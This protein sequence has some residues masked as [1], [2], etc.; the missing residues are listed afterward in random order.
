MKI[1]LFFYANLSNFSS[2]HITDSNL[3]SLQSNGDKPFAIY[4]I[5]RSQHP[6]KRWGTTYFRRVSTREVRG[7]GCLNNVDYG[8]DCTMKLL[9]KNKLKKTATL[10]SG[11]KKKGTTSKFRAASK[12]KLTPQQS[13]RIDR[14]GAI[15]TLLALEE[16]IMFDGAVLATGAEVVQEQ[17]T[18][19]QANE[20]QGSQALDDN[21]TVKTSSNPLTDH[22]DL[23]SALSTVTAPS[24]RNEIVF[25]D[26]NVDD[27]QTLME[28]IDANAEVIM[29]DSTRDGIEQMA[30]ILGD[31]SDIDAI[32]I[33]SHG[34]QGEL[35]VGTGTLSMESMQ[36][37]YADELS[38]INQVLTNEADWLIYGCNFG[39][40]EIGHEAVNL[41][42]EL[43]G[44]DI[45]ASNDLTGSADLGADW[46]LEVETGTIETVVAVNAEIQQV[47]VEVLADGD[48]AV[49]FQEGVDGYAST[50][51]T[52]LDEFTPDTSYPSQTTVEVDLSNGGGG[53]EHALIRFDNLFGSG[54]GQIP[55]GST[56]ISATLT[57]D[58][59]DESSA[60]ATI[61][62][63]RMLATWSES[64][65]W[66]SMTSGISINDVEASSTADATIPNPGSTGSKVIVGLENTLQ[67]W[68]DGATNHG[69]AIISDN[70]NGLEFSSSENGTTSLR[71]QLTV[72]YRTTGGDIMTGLVGLWNV[73]ANA[74]DSSGNTNHG[75][76][77]GGALID[78]TDL[79]DKVGAGKLSLDGTD[80]YVDLASH[81]GNFS[82]LNEGTISAWIKTTSNGAVETIFSIT[83]SGDNQ[84]YAQL[85]IKNGALAWDV[86]QDNV[87]QVDVTT[88]AV[89][90]DGSWHH[91][92]ISVS[93]SGNI[94]YIDGQKITDLNYNAGSS[95]SA[96]FFN[97][98]SNLDAMAIGR[99]IDTSIGVWFFDGLV[100][101]VRVYSRSLSVADIAELAAEAPVA[102]NDAATTAVDTAVTVNLTSN[103]ID[104]DSETIA[105]LDVGNPTNGTVVNN[106]DGT[107]TYT[108]T[109]SYTGG[110]TFT[111]L[112]ADLDDTVSY[113]RLDGNGTDA[114]GSN[115]GTLTG[116]T[117]VPG[118]F[119]NALS[120]DE[121]DDKVIVPDFAINNEFSLSFKMKIDDNSGSNFQYLYG[122]GAINGF[123]NLN[124]FLVEESHASGGMLRTWIRDSNDATGSNTDL[125]FD[126]SH[127]IGDGQ[128]HTYTVTVANGEGTKVYLDGVLK[129][130]DATRGGDAI[131]PGTDIHFGA[132]EDFATVADRLYGGSLES[133]QLFNRALSAEE[134]ND[135]H[136]GGSSLATVTIGVGDLVVDTASDVADGDTS[137]IGALMS[138]KG[139][140][141]FISLR[142]AITAANNTTNGAS[143]DEI[144]FSIGTGLQTITLGAGSGLPDITDPL[145]LDA[146]TQSGYAGT[147]IIQIDGT[148]ATGATAGLRL[149]TNDS[150]IK[151]F[152]IHS[153]A[154]EGLEIDGS[155]GFGDNNTLQNNWLG[156]D[157]TGA[158][159]PNTEHGILITD[160]AA[161][162]QIGGTGLNE[163]NVVS[164]NTLSGIYIRKAGSDN[165]IVEGN[166]IGVA[167]NGSTVVANST[168]GV[169][170]DD[171]ATGNVIG[172]TATNAGNVIANNTL[173]GIAVTGATTDNA[174]LGNSIHSNTGLGVDL[175]DDGLTF[176]DADDAD[177]GSNDL[178]NFPVLTNVVQSGS[179][180]DIDF[181]ADLPAGNYRIEFFDNASG[182]DS[183]DFGE[184]QTFVGFAHITAT[185]AAGYES[186][187]TTLSTVT[188]SN[189]LNITATA[190]EADGTYTTFSST[191]EFGPQFLGAGVLEVTTTSDVSDGDTSSIAAPMGN[192]GA[193]GE[194]SL[195][196]AI[197][198][199][200]NTTNIGGNPDEIHF[201]IT[202][203]LVSGAHTI[204]V[205]VSGLDNITDAVIIDGTTDSDFS[206]T[207][208]IVLD[209]SSTG[210]GVEGL[211]L[212][213]GSDGSTI[214]GLVV[215]QFMDDGIQ[216]T[217]D[218]NTIVGNYLGTDVAGTAA[219]GNGEE[220]VDISGA[221]N[222]IGGTTAAD[223]NII[224][225]NTADG[226]EI[227]G[228]G[229]TGNMVLGNYIGTDVTGMLDLGNGDDGIQIS[230]AATSNTIGGTTATARNIISGNNSRGI[231][232]YGSGTSSNVIQGNYIG[233]DV[234]GTGDL[235]NTDEGILIDTQATNN[236]VGGTAAG[237]G[238]VISENDSYGIQLDGVGTTG[239]LVQG[240]TIGL[241]QA[242][243]AILGNA[244]HGVWITN[245]ATSNTIGGTVAGAKNY[246]SGN[247]GSGVFMDAGAGINTVSGNTIG[248]GSDGLTD[249]GNTSHG[250]FTN[251]GNN[252]IGGTTVNERNVISGNAG[253]GVYLATGGDTN[254]ILGNYIGLDEG[255][256]IA[257]GNSMNGILI[258][259]ASNII[260]GTTAGARNVISGNTSTGITINSA[261]SNTVQG[262][263]IGTNAA[264][265]VILG[266]T[267]IGIDVG[268]SN[269]TI[270]G[271]TTGTTPGGAATGAA[272]VIAGHTTSDIE[273]DTSDSTIIQGNY[274]G[275]NAAGTTALNGGSTDYGI[276]V[277]TGS[278]TTTVG[279]ST[280]SA[281]NIIAGHTEAGIA[282]VST[283]T[284]INGGTVR[285]NYVGVDTTG[286]A[287]LGSDGM[288]IWIDSDVIN[289]TVGGTGADDGN[290]IAAASSGVATGYAGGVVVSS[291]LAATTPTDITIQGNLV[292][293]NASGVA[294]AP[295]ANERAGVLAIGSVQD[296]TIGGTAAGAGNTI[297]SSTTGVEISETIFSATTVTPSN[298]SVLG[299]S[300]LDNVGLGVDI[301]QDTIDDVDFNADSNQ[302]VTFNDTDDADT[303]VNDL[304]NFPVI[305]NV[306]QNGADVDINF[307]VDLPAGNYRIEFFDNANGLDSSGF[308][309]GETFVGFAH[310]TVTGA[311]GYEAFSTTLSTV[312]ASN[313]LNITT[314]VTEADGTFT[315]FSSTSEF[316]PQFL[317]AGV[318][319]VTTTSDTNDGDISSIAALMG[320]RGADGEISLR[321]AIIATNN[322][323]NIG[324]NSDEIHF[325]ISAALVSGAH[326]IQVG[327][328]TDGSN[329]AL[330]DITDAVIIDG[331]TD[332]D[333]ST[334][335]I[336]ELDGS[337]AGTSAEGITFGSGSSGSTMRGLVINQFDLAGLRIDNSDNNTVVGNYIGTNVTGMSALANTD[338]GI[339]IVN[340]SQSNT[341]GGTTTADQNIISGN[342]DDG[343]RIRGGADGNIIIGNYIGVDATGTG[344][345]GNSGDGIELD[346][347]GSDDNTIGGTAANEGNII[348]FNSGDG[349]T[350]SNIGARGN[351]VL[352]NSIHS[353]TGIGID[354]NDDGV[355]AN[356]ANDADTGTG[357]NNLQN[358]PVLV[359]A[360]TNGAGNIVIAGSLDTDGLTQ[361]Y[362]IEF[363]SNTVATGEDAT[364]HG[365]GEN[366][367]G[368]V[369]VTTD[370]SGDVVFGANLSATV[371]A[372]DFITATAT[373]DNGG[374]SYGDTSEFATNFTA[375]LGSLLVVDTTSDMLDGTVTS[376]SALIADKGADGVISLREAITATNNT[377]NIGGNP[378][379]IHFNISAALVSG[380]HTITPGSALP[381]ITDAVIIDGTTEPDFGS[382]PVIELD[383]TSAGGVDGL[384][385]TS[386]SNGSTIRGLAINRFL[387]GIG[388]DSANNI[389][390][391]NFIGTDVTG[392]TD[393]G[394]TRD[395][396][397]LMIGGTNNTIGGTT[398]AQ[399][400]LISGQDRDG[401]RIDD[402]ANNI[403][404]GNY[405]GTDITGTVDLG[406]TSDGIQLDGTSTGTTIG[407]TTS[408]HRNV[409]SGNNGDGI[410]LSIGADS[411]TIS[412]NIIGLDVNGTSDLGNGSNGIRV[413]SDSNTIGGL[414]AGERNIISGN[415][416]DGIDINAS[417]TNLIWGNYIGT[418]I[419]GTLDLGNAGE[420]ILIGGAATGNSIGGNTSGHRN[421]ISG[422]NA[423]GIDF[424]DTGTMSNTVE[425]NYIGVDATGT[426]V[427][428]NTSA[429]VDFR[430]GAQSN[431][432]GGASAGQRN[433]ISANNVGIQ[434]RDAGTDNNTILG[435]YVG[436]DVTGAVALGN[437]TRGIYVRGGSSGTTIGG[438]ATDAGNIIAASGDQGIE[439]DNSS[440]NT[441]QGNY[442]GTNA[443]DSA[444]LGNTNEGLFIDNSAANNTIGGTA[445]GAGNTIAYNSQEGLNLDSDAG[446]GNSILRN[447]IHSNSALG[448]D[449]DNDGV[450]TNDLGD[451]DGG[452]NAQ[453]NY[454]ILTAAVSDEVGT[455]TISGSLNSSASTDYRIE[456]FASPAADSS[457]YG[458]AETYI[459]FASVTT[460]GSGNATISEAI[461]ATV[462]AGQ[463]VT[464]TATVDFGGSYGDTSEFAQNI[465]VNNTLIVDTTSDVSDGDTS[466]IAALLADKG[467]DGFVSLREAITATNNTTNINGSTPDEI[468]FNISAALVSGA[469]TI[470]IGASQ[471]DGITDAVII[472]GNTDSDFS[473]TPIIVL[474]GSSTG[475]G[476]EGLDLDPGS[477]GSTIRGLV[478]N[479]FSGDGIQI[480]SDNNTIVGNYIGTDVT[481]T[482][483]LGNGDDG[484]D[485]S[486]ANNTIGGTTSADRNIISGNANDGIEID[487]AGATGN[488]IRGNYIGTDVTGALDLGNT[489]DGVQ[490][491]DGA[492]SNTI[493]GT[494]AAARNVISGNDGR[495]F[496]IYGSGTSNNII[497]GNYIGVDVSGVADLGN[498][499]DGILIDTQATSN[500]IG[501]TV[502]GAGNVISGND[503]NGIEIDG[504]GTTGNSVVGNYIGINATGTAAVGNSTEGV[505]IDS[506]A[507]SNTIGGTTTSAR[508]VI[509][510][511]AN[512]GI[513]LTDAGTDSNVIQGNFIGTNAAGTAAVAN[514]DR[515]IQVHT[516]VTNTQIG[517]NST[518]AGNVISGNMRDGIILTDTSS[519]TI[520]EGNVIGTDL[521]GTINIGNGDS[522]VRITTTANNKIGGAA[523]GAGNTI[524]Y[525]SEDGITLDNTAGTGNTLLRNTIH[526][527]SGIGIDL[528][529]DGVTAN[530]ANDADTGTGP[531]NLQNFPVLTEVDIDSP[532]QIT[533][534]GTLDTDG[535]NQDYR[536]E[537]FKNTI[538]TGEDSSN[539]GEGE[540]YLGFATVMTD[541]SGDATFS[542]TLTATVAAGEFITATAT[543]DNG[544]GS[545]GDTSEFGL[546]VTAAV[547]PDA[548]VI[549]NLDG[550]T[551]AYTEGAGAQVIDQST[552]AAVSDV[553]SSDFDTGTL[554]VSFTAGSTSSEDVLSIR[555]QGAG[556]SNIT[557]VGS[558]VSYGGTQIGTFT[559]GSSGAALVITL[560]S[561]AT[562]VATSAL[563]QNITYTN[564]NTDNPS[565]S[566]RTVRYVLT[567]G[568]G[569]TS[570]NYD[571]TVNVTAVNDAP[572]VGA[573][574]SA[575]AATEQTN[576][577]IEGTG[578]TVS[579]A[580][581]ASGT[582]TT[583]VT[584]GEGNLTVVVG[585]SGVTI[586]SGNG[587][588]TVVLTGT[589]TQLDNLLTSTS[590]GTI[591]YVNSSDT[592]MAST[593]L[594][595]T[596]NDQGNTGTDPGLSGDGTSEEG[597]NNVTINV[598]AVND[599]ATVATN[600]G[601]TVTE[602]GSVII[603]NL[604]L[605]E[606]DPDD[607][608]TG[609]TYRVAAD[610]NNGTLLV[611]G[612]AM[613]SNDT[614]TQADIDAGIVVY[615]H[616][617]AEDPTERVRLGIVDGGE[618]GAGETIFDFNITV[619]AVNDAPIGA[620]D[621]AGT[622]VD[623]ANDADTIGFW[624]L[625]E[626]AGTTATDSSVAGNDGTYTGGV[627]LGATGVSGSDTAADFD[628]SNDHVDLGTLEVNGTGITMAAWINADTFGG[629]DGRIFAKSDGTSNQNHTWMLSVIDIGPNIF[630][631]FRLSAGNYTE[632]LI[633]SSPS[634]STGQWYHV[635][636]TYDDTTG[637]MALYVDGQQIEFAEHSVGGAVDQDPTRSV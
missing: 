620:D 40:G 122:H 298:V 205:G 184:G 119:G 187:S 231:D 359:S 326:T 133:V 425:G 446:T 249:L 396:I 432:V 340:G 319:E 417:A 162:N 300:I 448:I 255:G 278:D 193:D 85:S 574:G 533:I 394:N 269:N 10:P 18:K 170:I 583:T 253:H 246:I 62:L 82:S 153:S 277:L 633:A 455:I 54:A 520:I 599:P 105:V 283:G 228:A 370:G 624:R 530:D 116:T 568:D 185:G 404:R 485:I 106:E 26:T 374:G 480:Q 274:I 445:S 285:G 215:N 603:T 171:T 123:S 563:V 588:S 273:L 345:L 621:P 613:K 130:T 407:G 612:V 368:F 261:N 258:E 348:A 450:T 289:I 564:T 328:V 24:G 475:A 456:F 53:Q 275:V 321:E 492:S 490:I 312:T 496:D 438:S 352:G 157:S 190:T 126:A 502:A 439:L 500:T 339:E 195:R 550:D 140:D 176:N 57:L 636:A 113:W 330:P 549:T 393:L 250:V 441:V 372:G 310:I 237:A 365:E 139:A 156:V 418:D 127:I 59:S 118:A 512:I 634:L 290:V 308:G 80:D 64:S 511:N 267:A 577:S 146:T 168:Y 400:N 149:L 364:M 102:T 175:T 244:G 208:I 199:T 630:L 515:G 379:E 16:R 508:N 259:S 470:A 301:T 200:N 142:E 516:G 271:G 606:G 631:R 453:Q 623:V 419:T 529:N 371:A 242:G 608:G 548:P 99:N 392:T 397:S 369:N 594:T 95:S 487:G 387:D 483:D 68:S 21:A 38:T 163:G 343:I 377:T 17:S 115:N 25:I 6:K 617:G 423:N 32:H 430:D 513:F 332:S 45:A 592:P 409:I 295:F 317:G 593:T 375:V 412:A 243:D 561:D 164:G 299:N 491:F 331:T 111:Y 270:L 567:D 565:T 615:K 252:T 566:A 416:S 117:T 305:T 143:P 235:G 251:S 92:A 580:D 129:N 460:D 602:G 66:N 218:N 201:E 540:I 71:P 173:D 578:F 280:T 443:V 3:H 322:T 13:E 424:R 248:L 297:A 256:T 435:N 547:V 151:G 136:T 575:L 542:T 595:V 537:F 341:I 632:N 103:D 37:E 562:A 346:A 265:T 414:T 584:V 282:F 12:E 433:I 521:T 236:T 381:D 260:G 358:F 437:T 1:A 112:T 402:A 384:Q 257:L 88:N 158:A 279:G 89:V 605:N 627:T 363:F 474:D 493:G 473:S 28:G 391:G 405:I 198:A 601:A 353:N 560:D 229:A 169:W 399:R 510:G 206:S 598:T 121:S 556:A 131:D 27:Y 178:L 367:L 296:I 619:T 134:V 528:S 221:N 318:L 114:V 50:Q 11:K 233:V 128:W 239:N 263:Y 19:D 307:E 189:V 467:A 336:I 316:G 262:N 609:I 96:N 48:T 626:L 58:V 505:R 534:A 213:S 378:D 349:I 366:Y 486:G 43:T 421:V 217:S 15:G 234:A 65:T 109:T 78:T 161:G 635:A 558:T 226:I 91:V 100:D 347:T 247:T 590:T 9:K 159:D 207:P 420:G 587:T 488:T 69:W 427:L 181:D 210:A 303:G 383:G 573:P 144:S 108:P 49:S 188:A 220:G 440:N 481:G 447:A 254:T 135:T 589:V 124:I 23:F 232:M 554:T 284:Q 46:D 56:I 63:H 76:L 524:A 501:G 519:G 182:L 622:V 167:P 585:D 356:D 30:E 525:N 390:E 137:S 357:A 306:V 219:L 204:A 398:A 70:G 60:S 498:T 628:G 518:G 36:G 637:A 197:T 212:D 174:F 444:I 165:N 325:N 532:T 477:S 386:G 385:L 539:H 527:N 572:V 150:T 86:E 536:I 93:T 315:T 509:S 292:G 110:D 559:G 138:D 428:G 607:S 180:L 31:R 362:R 145:I 571:T 553:D 462:A 401:I 373:V 166:L 192:R 395:G 541:G 449:L 337:S 569:G 618:D 125:E 342:S 79:T 382:T 552:N 436:T 141:G 288:G 177:T 451:G 344:S 494:S 227:D 604:M 429:G 350:L 81:V 87:D 489:D 463:V 616:T 29:L 535:L 84:S 376:I 44:A 286:T 413:Q 478:I 591:T 291:L 551:L 320:N 329:G 101:E 479:Q 203:A 39:E 629:G 461:S 415:D 8:P 287:A 264:G 426:V 314:S 499:F 196:E 611:G 351:T 454:P 323:T 506:G 469:H 41:L 104:L 266:S 311:A 75:T 465:I 354:L 557:V 73:D 586:S 543:V 5:S 52:H 132:R 484:I 472:D 523:S 476:L 186:F 581:A 225:G 179:D 4:L 544:G 410:S 183:S 422:N 61:S 582:L 194:I 33:I 245:G 466:S 614:F 191:S 35:Y 495:G 596:V 576:L 388:I 517:G 209:G 442:I 224:S 55:L 20:E 434:V 600:T 431:T 546:N 14:S 90:N 74:D 51:D 355:T 148:A 281:R 302:G 313:V 238:N 94:L 22:V 293:T 459:G 610:V 222:T 272:N 154:D 464:A 333:F 538:A 507:S 334:T 597:T 389:I 2:S 304:L 408:A 579:D 458:E 42:A 360:V 268:S 107:I 211:Y 47:W 324:G 335:P 338:N 327:N 83:D 555:D 216:V 406:N 468:H 625:G 120:F 411:T 504:T 514:T 152:I 526:S 503:N 97:D 457:G 471:L 545:Y 482:V 452:A 522:G 72:E 98:V 276:R 570:A 403:I 380:A 241:N 294:S 240:N 202:D 155:T 223:R 147:P 160:G 531:N 497:Q 309:E 77:T 214:R 67:A 230:G 172:G 361:D 34:N 7:A